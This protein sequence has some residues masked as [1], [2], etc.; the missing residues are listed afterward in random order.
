MSLATSGD[1]DAA[2]EK[3][4]CAVVEMPEP[5]TEEDTAVGE[6]QADQAQEEDSGDTSDSS[7][8]SGANDDE[9]DVSDGE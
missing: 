3:V 5:E 4:D 6:D 2:L 7:D 9:L 8:D 1:F